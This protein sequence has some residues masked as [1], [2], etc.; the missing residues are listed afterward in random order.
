MADKVSKTSNEP[1]LSQAQQHRNLADHTRQML[2]QYLV[3]HNN[4]IE[5]IQSS[6]MASGLQPYLDWWESFHTSL[7]NHA[8]LH[9]QMAAHLEDTVSGFDEVDNNTAQ[10]FNTETGPS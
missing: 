4:F 2:S 5:E 9:E 1:F 3:H 10:T 7:L 8:D 6:H